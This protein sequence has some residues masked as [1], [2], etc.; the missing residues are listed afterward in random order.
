MALPRTLDELMRVADPIQADWEFVTS[1]GVDVSIDTPVVNVGVAI[2]QGNLYIK[3]KGE[4][5]GRCLTYGGVG[6][7]VGYRPIPIPFNISGS[8]KEMI[9]SG[10]IYKMPLAGQTLHF[11]EFQGYCIFLQLGYQSWMGRCVTVMYTGASR[12]FCDML[13]PAKVTMIPALCRA[14]LVVTGDTANLVPGEVG[15]N[16]LIGVCQ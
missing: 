8:V 11:H 4:T 3:K 7:G 10:G 9:S 13:G 14:M 15:A 5:T 2:S 12:V 6:G 16:M 1:S